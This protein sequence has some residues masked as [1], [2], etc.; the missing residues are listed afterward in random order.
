MIK[1]YHEKNTIYS[2]VTFSSITCLSSS[3]FSWSLV[4]S[5]TIM[6]ITVVLGTSSSSTSTLRGK[7]VTGC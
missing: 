3:T 6:M 4:R 7:S 5:F 1:M 2:I